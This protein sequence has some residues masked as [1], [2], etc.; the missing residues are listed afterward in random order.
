MLCVH[1]MCQV[2]TGHRTEPGQHLCVRHATPHKDL[3]LS[4]ILEGQADAKPSCNA[5]GR[6]NEGH[7]SLLPR[8]WL[9]VG[10]LLTKSGMGDGK[11]MRDSP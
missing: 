2:H 3:E 4:S 1:A 5:R 9:E 8:Q 11:N 10:M 7:A 6:L